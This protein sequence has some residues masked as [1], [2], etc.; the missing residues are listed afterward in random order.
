MAKVTIP[1]QYRK[2][3]DN[4]PYFKSGLKRVMDIIEELVGVYPRL[5]PLLFD[6]SGALRSTVLYFVDR[7]DIRTLDGVDTPV[8]EDATLSIVPAIAG[9]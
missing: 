3:A 7:K 1:V 2:L 6:D 9:G 8:T 4:E 5:K